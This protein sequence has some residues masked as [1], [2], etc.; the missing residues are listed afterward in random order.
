MRKWILSK[1]KMSRGEF[2]RLSG[3]DRRDVARIIDGKRPR[4]GP[5]VAARIERATGGEVRAV[6]FFESP[7]HEIA[8]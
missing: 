1:K 3:L 2:A 5:D 7:D 8:A 4:V 6:W